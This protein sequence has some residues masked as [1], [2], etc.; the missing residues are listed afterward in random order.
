MLRPGAT[1]RN[2]AER[3]NI[4]TWRGRGSWHNAAMSTYR[5]VQLSATEWAVEFTPHGHPASQVKAGF[6]DEAAAA[7]EIEALLAADLREAE[8]P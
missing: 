4:P 8:E 2:A 1:V 5:A 3:Q 7:R 6:P